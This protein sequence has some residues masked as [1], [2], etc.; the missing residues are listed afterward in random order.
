MPIDLVVKPGLTV[1]K[2]EFLAT[3]PPYSI[4]L[5]GYVFGEPFLSTQ[6][7]GPH[8][9]FN[10]HE[11]VDR[12]CMSAT[13][14]QARRAVIMGLYEM[15]SDSHGRRATLYINDCDQDVCV[16]TWVLLNPE[17]A[18]E[19][20]VRALS[21]V[22]DLLDMSSGTF[23]MP[24][25]RD[26]LGEIRWVFE[27]YGR[28]RPF[29]ASMSSEQIRGVIFDVHHRIERFLMGRAQVLPLE[30]TYTRHGG[31]T[32]WALMEVS[33][34]HARE[35]MLL[36]GV[37]AAVEAYGKVG[38]NTLYALW[39]KSEYITSFPVPEVL[40]ALNLAEGFQ[41]VDL[42]GWGGSDNSGGSPR[43]RG[44]R[45]T[46]AEVE[47]IVNTVISTRVAA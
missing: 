24:H 38:Q 47:D 40:Q 18:A 28:Q 19:P 44:S 30:G 36:A 21:Q 29:L 20:L 5:D 6:V 10:H 12:S 17:R 46:L 7:N 1:T 31:G 23:P 34:L 15:F 22:E 9:S 45:L 11:A 32:G 41:A 2:S 27:P 39:R 16:A 35:K 4:A 26:L 43:G 42:T 25:E 33:G 8:R 14:E 37:H 3:H 13:C